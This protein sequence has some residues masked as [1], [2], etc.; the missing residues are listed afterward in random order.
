MACLNDE[1]TAS[2]AET[3]PLSAREESTL[4]DRSFLNNEEDGEEERDRVWC[5]LPEHR[6]TPVLICTADV[7][8]GLASGTMS[9]RYYPIFFLENLKLSPILVQVLFILSPM[10]QAIMMHFGQE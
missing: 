1:S 2:D 10:G 7:I 8:A 6:I 3:E 5:L 4:D 9:L